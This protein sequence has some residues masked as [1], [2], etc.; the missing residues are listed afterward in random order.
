MPNDEACIP[1]HKMSTYP[2]NKLRVFEDN[3]K[4]TMGEKQRAMKRSMYTVFFNCTEQVQAIGI[5]G[6][7]IVTD[8]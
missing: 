2:E 6:H 5:K 3:R 7:K 8:N 4:P 1:F